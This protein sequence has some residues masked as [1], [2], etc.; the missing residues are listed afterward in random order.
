[1][2][3]SKYIFVVKVN[4]EELIWAPPLSARKLSPVS[5]SASQMVQGENL[6]RYLEHLLAG[7]ARDRTRRHVD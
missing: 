3:Y 5:R 1:M 6:E 7:R 4:V 2:A